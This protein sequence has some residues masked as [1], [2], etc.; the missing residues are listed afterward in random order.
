LRER[1][2]K[3]PETATGKYIFSHGSSLGLMGE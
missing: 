1:G 3:T 2:I